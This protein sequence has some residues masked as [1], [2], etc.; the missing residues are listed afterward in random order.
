MLLAFLTGR[1]FLRLVLLV[2][3]VVASAA[4]ATAPALGGNSWGA[5]AIG[6]AFGFGA[7]WVVIYGPPDL[8][9]RPVAG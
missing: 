2:V 9:K 3:L 1:F 6:V 8:G 7:W 4:L 5:L